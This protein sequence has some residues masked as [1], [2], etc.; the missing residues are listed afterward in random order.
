MQPLRV[1]F[2]AAW[3]LAHLLMLQAMTLHA[4]AKHTFAIRRTRRSPIP[5]ARFSSEFVASIPARTLYRSFHAGVCWRACISSL[6][7]IS[8]VISKRKSP[9]VS[10]GEQPLLR[11]LGALTGQRP[12]IWHNRHVFPSKMAWR[13]RRVVLLPLSMRWSMGLCPRGIQL[14]DPPSQN[15]RGLFPLCRKKEIM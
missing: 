14:P 13:E 15:G 7:R 9:M 1:S 4:T 6:K 11:W 3:A 12:S 5:W 10:R 8:G 2:N